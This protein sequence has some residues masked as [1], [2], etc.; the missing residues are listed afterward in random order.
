MGKDV[1]NLHK[2]S[3]VYG[4]HFKTRMFLNNL[5]KGLKYGAVPTLFWSLERISSD[6]TYCTFVPNEE[7]KY[8]LS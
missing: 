7:G 1:A 2:R 6:H 3:R 8:M 5:R 4:L